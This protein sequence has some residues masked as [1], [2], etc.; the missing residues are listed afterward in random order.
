VVR[1][2]DREVP[3]IDD[4][5]LVGLSG[6]AGEHKGGAVII[7]RLSAEHM[8]GVRI[9]RVRRI[10]PLNDRSVHPLAET[11][12]AQLHC[13]SGA[14][15]DHDGRQN[16]LLDSAALLRNEPLQTIAA[17]TRKVGDGEGTVAAGTGSGGGTR[18]PFLVFRA[19]SRQR[20][21]ALASV[22]Q[23]IPF[24]GTR[25]DLRRDEAGSGLQGV[26][27]F[28]GAPLPLLDLA[29]PEAGPGAVASER[30]VL[31]VERDGTYNGL[32]VDRLETVARAV[33]MPRPGPGTA[34]FIEAKVAG[35]TEAVTLCDLAEEARRLA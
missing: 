31:V 15:V 14:V 11:L 33:A 26:A 18:Q 29:G 5:A 21:A 24:P 19:G 25:T 8:L 2:L 16:L 32:I 9:D 23:I 12:A 1:Y 17:L 7:L 20:A 27:S 35:K 13:F 4:L 10:L 6:R 28:N 30:V 3:V 34:Q 22:K